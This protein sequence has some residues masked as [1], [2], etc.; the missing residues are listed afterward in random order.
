MRP[1]ET[2]SVP[3][4]SSVFAAASGAAGAEVGVVSEKS[5]TGAAVP[6]VEGPRKAQTGVRRPAGRT[7]MEKP[8]G[9]L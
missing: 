8:G 9:H 3:A 5:N 1:L 6:S 4:G 7:R 2:L